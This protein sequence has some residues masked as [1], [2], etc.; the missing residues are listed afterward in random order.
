MLPQQGPNNADYIM[1]LTE[2]LRLALEELRGFKALFSYCAVAAMDDKGVVRVPVP[3][4][5][6]TEKIETLEFKQ[7]ELANGKPG[8]LRVKLSFVEGAKIPK[9]KQPKG[10]KK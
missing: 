3:L 1:E 9:A 5:R 2:K 4:V 6:L 10:G 8:A 7:N